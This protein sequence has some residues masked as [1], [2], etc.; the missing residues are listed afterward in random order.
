MG[1]FYYITAIDEIVDLIII[2][3]EHI[4][5]SKKMSEGEIRVH[6]RKLRGRVWYSYTRDIQFQMQI[7]SVNG[8]LLILTTGSVA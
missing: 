2:L 7:F 8:P 3:V 6:A 4:T 1:F 5:A